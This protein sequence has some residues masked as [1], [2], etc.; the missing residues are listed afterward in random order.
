MVCQFR[1]YPS[2]FF[3]GFVC[4]SVFRKA[5]R[6]LD[7]FGFQNSVA[8]IHWLSE[9]SERSASHTNYPWSVERSRTSHE[10]LRLPCESSQWCGVCCR[11]PRS[12]PPDLSLVSRSLPAGLIRSWPR[13][14]LRFSHSQLPRMPCQDAGVSA[15]LSQVCVE[16]L[17]S[18]QSCKSQTAQQIKSW[19]S[20]RM[21]TESLFSVPSRFY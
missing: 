7:A 16:D 18:T 6:L 19:T 21:R 11:T 9:D 20:E 15:E 1:V 12:P 3:T 4:Y 10:I 17:T 14:P 8:A 13:A 5:P 2:V